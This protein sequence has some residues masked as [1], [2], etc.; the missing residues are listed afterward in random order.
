MMIDL[1]LDAANS[2]I[3]TFDFSALD[4]T[5]FHLN[6]QTLTATAQQFNQDVTKDL[7]GG[8]NNFIK[9]GQVWALVIGVTL[10]YLFKSITSF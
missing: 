1:G 5:H 9:S 8:W 7:A 6:W 3:A 4:L 10:G 2:M